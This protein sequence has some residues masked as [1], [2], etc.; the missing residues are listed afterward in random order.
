MQR[1]PAAAPTP[2][3]PA[4]L[5]AL[6]RQLL[7]HV[8]LQPAHHHAPHLRSQTHP[9]NAAHAQ[10]AELLAAAMVAAAACVQHATCKAPA[11]HQQA[12]QLHQAR[13]P[14]VVPAHALLAARPDAPAAT[15]GHEAAVA[16]PGE[17]DG[18]RGDGLQVRM[19]LSLSPV[20]IC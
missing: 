15:H 4:H 8:A 13:A 6:G 10:Q 14:R 17:Q 19:M 11:T 18:G 2:H 9:Q 1:L 16:V 20:C 12:V 7:Q 3:E 5:S